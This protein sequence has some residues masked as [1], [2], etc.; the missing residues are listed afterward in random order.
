ME[1]IKVTE[2]QTESDRI[3]AEIQDLEIALSM[4]LEA[5]DRIILQ[6]AALKLRRAAVELAVTPSVQAAMAA[7]AQGREA[8]GGILDRVTRIVK[9]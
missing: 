6:I 3:T 8:L 7:I 1:E 5:T 9:R 4:A 2:M